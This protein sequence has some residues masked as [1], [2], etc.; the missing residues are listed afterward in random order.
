MRKELVAAL[1]EL[2]YAFHVNNQNH[3]FNLGEVNISQQL[4][5]IVDEATEAHEEYRSGHAPNYVYYSDT[6]KPEGLPTELADIIVRTLALAAALDIDIGLVLEE[7]HE[8][9]VSR[10]FKH[11]RVF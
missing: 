6:G 2:A 3:G 10:P 11:D 9:N 7:K 1:N 8:Y 4:M 5:L